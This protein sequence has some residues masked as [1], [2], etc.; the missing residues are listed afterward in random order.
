MNTLFTGRNTIELGS[1]DSTNSYANECLK[2]ENLPEGTVIWT[3]NQTDGRGQR[4]NFWESE[5]FKNITFSVVVRPSFLSASKQFFLNKIVSLAVADFVAA[6]LGETDKK[7]IVRIKWPNDI[8]VDDKK[9]AGILIENSLRNDQIQSSVMGI[10]I[11]INQEKFSLVASVPVS[12]KLI[13]KTDFDLEECLSKSCSFLE[14]RYLLLRS[15][16]FNAL[17]EAYKKMLYRFEEWSNFIVG[18]RKM[19]ARIIDIS[20]EGKLVMETVDK[21]R[22]EYGF[23]EIVFVI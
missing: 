20:E 22:L 7:G 2:N 4:G 11:N 23:K 5:P 19:N 1:V 8:Y 6:I 13:C 21:R 15:G 10:G 18:E 9:I 3:K 14:A 16:K 12:L 17:D